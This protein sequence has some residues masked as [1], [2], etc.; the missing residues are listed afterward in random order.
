MPDHSLSLVG[1]CFHIKV[2]KPLQLEP[3]LLFLIRKTSAAKLAN[4]NKPEAQL[5]DPTSSSIIG[6]PIP[7]KLHLVLAAKAD[8][9]APAS[10]HRQGYRHTPYPVQLV[11]PPARPE[12]DL[13]FPAPNN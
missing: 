13:L 5:S 3:C 1:H 4:A 9:Y 8:A 10:V 2:G 6:S 11:Y 7:A 12:D